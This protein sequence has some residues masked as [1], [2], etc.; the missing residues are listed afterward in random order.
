L[1]ETFLRAPRQE[2]SMN[3]LFLQMPIPLHRTNLLFSTSLCVAFQ[4]AGMIA[5]YFMKYTKRS[6]IFVLIGVPLCVLGMGVLLYLVDMGD[7]RIGKEAAF[8]TAKSLVGIGRGSI[9]RQHRS[10]CKPWFRCKKF[11]L[12]LRCSFA[13]MSVGGAVGTRW[14]VLRN[15]VLL[16]FILTNVQQCRQSNMAKHSA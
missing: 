4:V 10:P 8:M 6:Q 9:K 11:W 7:G 13:S 14:E 15:S 5:T 16:S 3:L 12:L 2:L 1:L